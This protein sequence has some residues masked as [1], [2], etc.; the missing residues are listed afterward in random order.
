MVA[1][2]VIGNVER[3]KEAIIR[4]YF[5]QFSNQLIG[6]LRINFTQSVMSVM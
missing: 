3:L 4:H 5:G 1:V 6:I 2:N